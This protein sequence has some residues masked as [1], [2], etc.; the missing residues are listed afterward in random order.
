MM[1]FVLLTYGGW[2]EAA[3]VSAEL[4]DVRRNM[5]RALFLSLLIITILYVVINFAYLRAL[6]LA[7]VGA[8]QLVAADVMR[9]AFGEG[10]AGL[11]SVLV[12]ISALTSANATVFTGGRSSYAFGQDFPVFGYLGQWSSRTG[13]PFNALLVQGVVALVLVVLGV[14]TRRGFETIVE[15]TAPVFWFF[16]MVTGV[17]LFV[18]RRKEPRRERPF[19]VPL[20]PVTPMLFCLTSAYLLYSSLAYTGIGALIG[21]AVLAVGAVILL[22]VRPGET[23]QT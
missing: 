19:G 2:N 1:V 12:A 7:G 17:T 16:F 13:T 11:I 20:Y 10:G 9:R 18:L 15:Y 8:S 4:R 3:F 21:V 5:M 6:G 14:F 22:F 23:A